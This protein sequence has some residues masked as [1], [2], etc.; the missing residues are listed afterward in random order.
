MT[1][2][3]PS[4]IATVALGG[5]AEADPTVV[6]ALVAALAV[7]AAAFV[8]RRV[9]EGASARTV[10]DRPRPEGRRG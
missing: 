6:G 3:A 4:A 1:S 8:V 7:F 9:R 2:A 5:Y 10:S